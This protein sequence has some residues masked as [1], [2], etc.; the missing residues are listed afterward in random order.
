MIKPRR[1][2][3]LLAATSV[4]VVLGGVT[5]TAAFAY[6]PPKLPPP[7]ARCLLSTI[8]GRRVAIICNAG[9]RRAG[10]RCS[11]AV[12]RRTVA[13]GRIGKNGVYSTRFI[14]PTL[15]TRGTKIFFLVEGTTLASVRV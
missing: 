15:L 11:I 7:Q 8:V 5:A 14:V 6:P 3:R 1:R 2:R 12:A 9:V 10:K 4:F 13:R